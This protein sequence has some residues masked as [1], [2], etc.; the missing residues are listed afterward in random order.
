MTS[1]HSTIYTLKENTNS[2]S[3]L[4]SDTNNY[5]KQAPVYKNKPVHEG[6]MFLL[7]AAS[8]SSAININNSN[9]HSSFSSVSQCSIYGFD[10]NREN[11]DVL[12]DFISNLIN[13]SEDLDGQIVDM[14]NEKFW[15]LI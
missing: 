1:T 14:V 6:L 10:N 7:I 2:V 13:N 3:S 15:D 5:I 11:F 12:H 8:I 4:Y 9:I